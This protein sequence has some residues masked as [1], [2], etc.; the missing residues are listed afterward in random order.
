MEVSWDIPRLQSLEQLWDPSRRSSKLIGSPFPYSLPRSVP[1]LENQ[2]GNLCKWDRRLD[3]T[4]MVED[5]CNSIKSRQWRDLPNIKPIWLCSVGNGLV[6][7]FLHW[8]NRCNLL[9]T[10][11]LEYDEHTKKAW[12]TRFMANLGCPKSSEVV[13]PTV[14]VHQTIYPDSRC[15]LN[16]S[17]CQLPINSVWP[18]IYATTVCVSLHAYQ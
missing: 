18:S 2:Q 15:G 6:M 3:S 16:H 1:F 10:K 12:M 17:W 5:T 9:G 11:P 4:A 7:L 8:L 14:R 13:S